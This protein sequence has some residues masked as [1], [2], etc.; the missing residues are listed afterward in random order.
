MK[1][2]ELIEDKF[3]NESY[4]IME[5]HDIPSLKQIVEKRKIKEYEAKIIVN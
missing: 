5:W 3:Y 2:Y 4:L 1:V